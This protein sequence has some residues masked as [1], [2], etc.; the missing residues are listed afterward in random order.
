MQQNG[1]FQFCYQSMK[2][3]FSTNK[4]IKPPHFVMGN[5]MQFKKVA[6]LLNFLFLWDDEENWISWGSKPYWAILQKSFK[7]VERQLEYR[8]AEKW[9]NK[10]LHF[11]HLMHWILLYP[12]NT[13]FILSTKTSYS[14]RLRQQMMWFLA[15]YTNLEKVELLVC[16]MLYML[17]N[18]LWAAHQQ[19][20]K[21]RQN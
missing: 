18:I 7:L 12:S 19:M 5:K 9:L 10:F 2:E 21:N 17:F 4:V 6:D 8:K 1:K 14:Q 20:F 11:I 16:S 3:M 15:V 13:A